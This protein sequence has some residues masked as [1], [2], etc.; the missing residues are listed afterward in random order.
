M[1]KNILL[2]IKKATVYV[3]ALLSEMFINNGYAK[4]RIAD[5]LNAQKYIPDVS[6][7]LLRK[8]RKDKSTNIV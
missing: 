1:P 5:E 4:V 3:G 7:F 6:F 2:T 8:K